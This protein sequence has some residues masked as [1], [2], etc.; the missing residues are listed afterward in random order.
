[1]KFTI[2]I[3]TVLVLL[4][5]CSAP[6][7]DLKPQFTK[8]ETLPNDRGH[9]VFNTFDVPKGNGELFIRFMFGMPRGIEAS[10][11]D[12]TDDLVYLGTYKAG[13]SGFLEYDAPIGK[14]V[15]MITFP[16]FPKPLGIDHTDFIE[17]NVSKEKMTHIAISQ[18]GLMQMSYLSEIAI[19]DKHFDYC[20]EL[21]GKYDVRE[22]NI[23]KYMSANKID[24]NAKY[25]LGYCR[26]LSNN[27]RSIITPN[28]NGY[29]SF[30]ANKLKVQQ[31]KEKNFQEWKKSYVRQD[32]FDMLQPFKLFRTAAADSNETNEYN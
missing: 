32:P 16:D 8:K 4:V 3:I 18:Y 22:E 20:T 7:T 17:V 28:A 11:Y 9:V 21:T 5:G 14:R 15:F 25:F 29:A 26:M 27:F 30:E 2:Y 24:P 19:E 12:V 31:L 6:M 1:M 10:I 13:R 23:V